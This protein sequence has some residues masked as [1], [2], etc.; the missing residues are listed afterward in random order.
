MVQQFRDFL[1]SNDHRIECCAVCG[2][3]VRKSE[4]SC[5]ESSTKE[6]QLIRNREERDGGAHYLDRCGARQ[7]PGVEPEGTSW[8]DITNSPYYNICFSCSKELSQGRLPRLSIAN[9]MNVGCCQDEPLHLAGLTQLEEIVISR[10]RAFGSIIKLRAVG[11]SPDACYRRVKGHV[12]VVPLRPQSLLNVLPCTENDL[13]DRIQVKF[14]SDKVNVMGRWTGM[15][16]V[17]VSCRM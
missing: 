3:L 2:Q 10:S 6:V 5:F 7:Q 16:G 17:E 15:E 12:V 9:G 13:V 4:L 1:M 11:M 14:H 8:L